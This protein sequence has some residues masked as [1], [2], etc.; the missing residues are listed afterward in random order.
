MNL[1]KPIDFHSETTKR[2]ARTGLIVV[3]AA[4]SGWALWYHYQLAPWTRNGRVRVQVANV[5]PEI[6]G[7]IVGIMV[8]DNQ[9]VKKGDPLF[10]LCDDDYRF[11]LAQ[12]EA[13]VEAT[14]AEMEVQRENAARRERIGPM[15]VS[16]EEIETAS[17][18]AVRAHAAHAAA[19]AARDQAR[20]NLDRTVISAPVDGYV[21]NLA[22][23]I[24]DF[25]RPG[26]IKVSLVDEHSFW[27]SAYFEET[28]LPRIHEGNRVRIRLMGVGPELEGK[29]DSISRGIADANTATGAQNLPA[30]DPVFTWVRLAQRIPVRIEIGEVPEGV[31]L[32][33]G[34]TCTVVVRP[35][36]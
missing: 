28:K 5:A 20:L 35:S 11:A 26:E 14:G 10:A 18:A 15:A 13:Q 21:T 1:M 29:V 7:K 2:Y 9:R 8:R 27:I 12:A 24:G 25:A 32:A 33:A 6:G 3:L 31:V 36:R 34:Q 22:M 17:S 4:L 19:V 30:V 23:R 16:Q